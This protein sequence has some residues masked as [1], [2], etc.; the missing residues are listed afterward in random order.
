MS[1]TK[2]L[3]H[4]IY[5]NKKTNSASWVVLLHG[6]GGNSKIWFKQL[7]QFRKHYH[8]IAID[9]PGH[10]PNSTMEEWENEFSIEKC[11]DMIIDVL[12]EHQIEKAHFVGVS[13]GSVIIHQIVKRHKDRVNSAVLGGMIL[14]FNLFSRFLIFAGHSLKKI[15]PYM[16]LYQLFAHIM[17]PKNNH[18]QSRAMF[19]TEA[20][21]M[22]RVEFLRW[23]KLTRQV[24]ETS[25]NIEEYDV[26]RLYISGSEDHLFI[27]EL[28]KNMVNDH[29]GE[30]IEIDNCGHVCNVEKSEEFNF[31]ALSF[32]G[33]FS[34]KKGA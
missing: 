9:L 14:Q 6:I 5:F 8:V 4:Q 28:K 10:Y 11:T 1:L 34:N 26:P 23:F 12:N 7:K 32:L 27:N 3:H 13:L 30:L 17:M 33:Q 18:K 24:Q 15:L 19:I 29:F 31:H 21:K 25:E 16:W 22:H 2:L 20:K